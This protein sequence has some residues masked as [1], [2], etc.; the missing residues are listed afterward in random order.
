MGAGGLLRIWGD[1][2]TLVA[3]VAGLQGD[4]LKFGSP[5]A[6]RLSLSFILDHFFMITFELDGTK[7]RLVEKVFLFTTYLTLHRSHWLFLSS[8]KR[9]SGSKAD[10]EDPPCWGQ[11][12]G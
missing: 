8:V 7:L 2:V 10:L 5:L 3:D 11:A 4:R 1:T 6:S 12:N 9:V